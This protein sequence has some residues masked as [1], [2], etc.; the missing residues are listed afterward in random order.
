VKICIKGSGA[1]GKVEGWLSEVREFD[2]VVL[3]F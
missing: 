3:Q 2:A 1:S